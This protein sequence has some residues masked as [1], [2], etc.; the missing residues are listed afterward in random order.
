MIPESHMISSNMIRMNIPFNHLRE[1]C[2]DNTGTIG[3]WSQDPVLVSNGITNIDKRIKLIR[4]ITNLF[5]TSGFG[6]DV[7]WTSSSSGLIVVEKRGMRDKNNIGGPIPQSN[8]IFQSE[9]ASE[10]KDNMFN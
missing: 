7:Y 2:I 10:W 8:N 6:V 4:I 5:P 1:S 9:R 3:S